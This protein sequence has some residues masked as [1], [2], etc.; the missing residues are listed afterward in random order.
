MEDAF[1]P[2]SRAR[3]ALILGASFPALLMTWLVLSF[4][5]LCL[6]LDALAHDS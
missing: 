3:S 4:T 1:V 5:G 2:L 6:A